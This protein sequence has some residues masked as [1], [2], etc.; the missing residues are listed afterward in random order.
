MRRAAVI[1]C[2]LLSGCL[3]EERMAAQS[4]KDDQQCLSYGAQR[5]SDAYVACRTQL[6][7]T[8][9]SYICTPANGSTICY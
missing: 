3:R 5:G 2:L 8:K 6:S 9:T 1:L 4:A 7:T